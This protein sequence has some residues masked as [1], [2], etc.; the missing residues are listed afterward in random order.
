MIYIY[1]FCYA[2]SNFN[3]NNFLYIIPYKLFTFLSNK[4]NKMIIIR[5]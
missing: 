2:N 5:L 3:H 4:I 1:V